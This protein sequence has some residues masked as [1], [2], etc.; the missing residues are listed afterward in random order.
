MLDVLREDLR[1]TGTKKL[2]RSDMRLLFV[3]HEW[4]ACEQLPVP[5]L[6]AEAPAFR[7][8]KGLH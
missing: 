8:S 3:R 7:P 1:L 6:Q 5:V 4:R 2:R